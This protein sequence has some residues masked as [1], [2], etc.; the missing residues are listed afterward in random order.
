M[1]IHF[2]A[3]REFDEVPI[4]DQISQETGIEYSYST[5]YPTYENVQELSGCEAISCTPCDMGEK[6][7]TLLHERGVKYILCRSIGYD[8][9]DLKTAKS[10][11]MRVST[12]TYPPETVANYAIMCILMALRKIPYIM[13][14][15]EVQDYSLNGKIGRDISSLTVGVIGTG[16]IGSTVINHLSSFG[17]RLLAYDPYPKEE[18]RQY[19]EY[20]DLQTMFKEADVFTLHAN[21]T[22]EN[23]HLL[24]KEAFDMMKKDAVIVNTARGKLIDA[25][26]LIEAL[27][28]GN[29]GGAVLDVLENENGLFYYNRAGDVIANREMALLR[30]FPN[31]LLLPHTAFYTDITVQ[32][33]IQSIFDAADAF[34]KGTDTSHELKF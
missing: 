27:E 11:G 26:A 30:S 4:A 22:A 32:N 33:M 24:N 18:V 21:A 3:M 1:K 28:N 25:D 2:Y 14:K 8:H 16:S 9:V 20:V 5:E 12:V 19:A 10:L 23:M 17:C 34:D 13:K 29:L 31:V 7:L 15:S 6:M